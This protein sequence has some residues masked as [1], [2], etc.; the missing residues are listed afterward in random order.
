[1]GIYTGSS[2]IL[3]AGAIILIPLYTKFLTP[4][5]YGI[6]SLIA[7]I[8][9]IIL[10]ITYLGLD[11]SL[12]RYW[13]NVEDNRN[14]HKSMMSTIITSYLIWAIIFL[15]IF[16]ILQ[17]WIIGALINDYEAIADYLPIGYAIIFFSFFQKILKDVFIYEGKS[18]TFSYFNILQLIISVIL[19]VI[20]V[21]YF[22]LELW[23]IYSVNLFI[24]LSIAI[25]GIFYLK[26]YL[27]GKISIISLKKYLQF[28]IPLIPHVLSFTLLAVIGRIILE[29]HVLLST[30]GIF[31]LGYTLGSS[32]DLIGKGFRRAFN[33]TFLRKTEKEYRDN[34]LNN[35]YINFGKE[36]FPKILVCF[37][38][39]YFLY[40]LWI[41]EVCLVLIKNS[42]YF[43]CYNIIPIL[44]IGYM[45]IIISNVLKMVLFYEKHTKH[46]TSTT[47][48]SALINIILCLLLIPLWGIYGAAISITISLILR[49]IMIMLLVVRISKMKINYLKLSGF[50]FLAISCVGI[51]FYIDK[52]NFYFSPTIIL[53]KIIISI[54]ILYIIFFKI[55]KNYN[56][57]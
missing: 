40:F 15:G 1:M 6:M 36:Y 29:K 34:K 25:I 20:A 33:P 35:F 46:I 23:G 12:K 14:L 5:Q 57:I 7:A 18:I 4:D 3:K 49:S 22:N 56:L 37:L 32:V 24:N 31:G 26:K 38:S 48:I 8:M 21:G 50:F 41:K 43:E 45:F 42:D 11:E 17:K 54:I 39:L 55:I 30:L 53:F 13:V 51:T 44:I 28:G 47:V 9:S 27:F 2:V 19:S 10:S 52:A 16:Y